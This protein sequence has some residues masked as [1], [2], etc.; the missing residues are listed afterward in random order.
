MLEKFT[1][2]YCDFDVL[3]FPKRTVVSQDLVFGLNATSK[4]KH[5]VMPPL[6]W[7][8]EGNISGSWWHG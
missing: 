4:P 5:V 1:Y 8:I 6:T 3:V 7:R 2:S